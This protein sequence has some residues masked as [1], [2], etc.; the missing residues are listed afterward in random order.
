MNPIIEELKNEDGRYKIR[1]LSDYKIQLEYKVPI[2]AAC[3]TG[4]THE[5][6]IR[7]IDTIR[8]KV[9]YR[10][11][12]DER[13]HSNE[14]PTY[15]LIPFK[16]R[17]LQ[18]LSQNWKIKKKFIFLQ[19]K[20]GLHTIDGYLISGLYCGFIFND[21]SWTRDYLINKILENEARRN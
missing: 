3:D 21:K 2:F 10:I 17:F 13:R 8:I 20:S 5:D 15:H 11:D 1:R 14:L 18:I 7:V 6:S 9:R 16:D 12:P 19:R 4:L